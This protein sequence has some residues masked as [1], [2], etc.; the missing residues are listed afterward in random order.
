[1]NHG[2]GARTGAPTSASAAVPGTG[3]VELVHDPSGRGVTVLLDGFAQS[4][5]DLDDPGNLGF[6]YLHHMAAVIDSL[7]PGRLTVTH[8]GGGGLSLP[9]YVEATR[10]GSTQLV[11]EPSAVLTAVIRRELPLPR[12]HRIRVRQVGGAEGIGGL[13]PARAD[14][15]IVDA[16]ERGRIP[17]SLVTTGFWASAGAILRADGVAMVNVA[18]D[19]ARRFLARLAAGIGLTF[20]H[21][22]LLG[23]HDVL[24]AR[25]FGNSVVVASRQPLDVDELRRRLLR[26]PVPGGVLAGSSLGRLVRSARPFTGDD[27][28]PSPVPPEPGSWRRR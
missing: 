14:L 6:E 28:E 21:Q 19:P 18:D 17:A 20:P 27:C 4:F 11:L 3:T 9:R 15:L 16:F 12:R 8:V 7:P 2:A 25:R 24:K 1:M 26:S 22:A 23:T 13:P 10:A 5:V